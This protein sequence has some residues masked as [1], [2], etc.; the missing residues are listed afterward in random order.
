MGDMKDMPMKEMPMKD[1]QMGTSVQGQTH[2]ASGTV[3]K[4]DAAKG[5]VTFAHGPVKS[6][7]WPAMTMGFRVKDK[8]LLDKL[9]VGKQAEFEF[10]QEGSNYV[11]TAVR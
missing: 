5:S 10:V 1:M 3:K 9:A 6:L 11:V 4:V 7:N 2:H 8:T